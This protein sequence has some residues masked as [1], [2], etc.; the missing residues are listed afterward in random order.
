LYH[1]HR[2][3]PIDIPI[4]HC[5]PLLPHLL[6]LPNYNLKSMQCVVNPK[7]GIDLE[8]KH[9]SLI[10]SIYQQYLY[11]QNY[12][13]QSQPDKSPIH[14]LFTVHVDDC[15]SMF[16]FPTF[17]VPEFQ[18]NN[19]TNFM[20]PWFFTYS[21]MFIQNHFFTRIVVSIEDSKIGNLQFGPLSVISTNKSPSIEC[22]IP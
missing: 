22:I 9:N 15:P 20:N 16:D 5:H 10:N 21:N 2:L 1:L 13:T 17:H 8:K 14:R 4:V 7:S 19:F 6:V 18:V 11:L 12:E 3:L